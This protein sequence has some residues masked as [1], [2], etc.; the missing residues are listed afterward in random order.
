MSVNASS[1]I[2]SGA[3]TNPLTTLAIISRSK[4]VRE[5]LEFTL[6]MVVEIICF[7]IVLRS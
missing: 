3:E 1:S 6:L 5:S 7:E 2:R 4:G